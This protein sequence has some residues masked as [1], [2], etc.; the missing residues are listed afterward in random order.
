MASRIAGSSR[1]TDVSAEPR[2]RRAFQELDAKA[3]AEITPAQPNETL[4]RELAFNYLDCPPT[5]A[6]CDPL[7]ERVL[8]RLPVTSPSF[9][10]VNHTLSDEAI[11]NLHE[12][13]ALGVEQITGEPYRGTIRGRR[14]YEKPRT[15]SQSRV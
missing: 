14:R 10:I 7:E 15:G 6:I 2:S 4:W 8:R 9:V 12:V 11:A 1:R 13:L 3:H 5:E